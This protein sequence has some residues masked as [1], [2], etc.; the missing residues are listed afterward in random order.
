MM[1]GVRQTVPFSYY[2]AQLWI[3]NK[4]LFSVSFD[5]ARQELHLTF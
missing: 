1:V 4:S 3:P 2:L 5:D